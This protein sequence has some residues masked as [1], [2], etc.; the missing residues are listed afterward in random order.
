MPRNVPLSIP[1][2]SLSTP[3]PEPAPLPGGA[4]GQEGRQPGQKQMRFAL[5]SVEKKDRESR[6][7]HVEPKQPYQAFLNLHRHANAV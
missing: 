4:A 6:Q 5:L 7:N 2:S 3:P 1:A